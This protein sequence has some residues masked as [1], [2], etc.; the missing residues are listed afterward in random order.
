MKNM[1]SLFDHTTAISIDEIFKESN[2]Y[3]TISISKDSIERGMSFK[4][5]I[6][7]VSLKTYIDVSYVCGLNAMRLNLTILNGDNCWLPELPEY[8]RY[9]FIKNQAGPRNKMY[10]EFA[11]WCV[12]ESKYKAYYSSSKNSKC[13]IENQIKMGWP[14]IVFISD[15]FN[16]HYFVI[17]AIKY[18]FLNDNKEWQAI[19]CFSNRGHLLK[20][21]NM[22]WFWKAFRVD[23]WW[24]WDYYACSIAE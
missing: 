1:N 23:L 10:Q 16:A 2:D 11:N 5:Y 14:V 18:K 21:E 22:N 24:N 7:V 8:E 4:R 15:G 20:L 6:D 3:E 12:R 13:F 9:C 17:C 19:Y